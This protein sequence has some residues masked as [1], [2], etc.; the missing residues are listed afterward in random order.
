MNA[1]VNAT[2]TL[3]GILIPLLFAARAILGRLKADACRR[4]TDIGQA[5][6]KLPIPRPD[7]LI[8]PGA[9]SHRQAAAGSTTLPR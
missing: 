1:L 9:L 8:R 5:A 6:V 2:L 4:L 7:S 3:V